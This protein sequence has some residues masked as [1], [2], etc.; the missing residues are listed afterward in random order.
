VLC[1]P[2]GQEAIRS[3][4]MFRVLADRLS[5]D[6]LY[7][8]RFDY[9][10]TGDAAGEDHEGDIEGW[11]DDLLRAN[12]EAVRLS[13]CTRC[14][15]LGLRLGASIA[16]LASAKTAVSPDQLVLWDPIIDGAA[17]LTELAH[18]HIT[19]SAAVYGAR[20]LIENRLRDRALVE[21]DTEAIGFPLTPILKS[22]LRQ[23]SLTSFN[24]THAGRVDLFCE[25]ATGSIS[26]LQQRLVSNGI[27]VSTHWIPTEIDWMTTEAMNTS[28]VPVQALEQIAVSLLGH[29]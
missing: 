17:Y 25:S 6:G 3:H 11:I 26:E 21:S 2:F 13:G 1:N 15:W 20:W 19:E 9:Y 27:D 28:L 4:R 29:P 16:A 23:M 10:G 14:S 22:Q 18:A 12:D 7:V 5:R 8:L 24:A